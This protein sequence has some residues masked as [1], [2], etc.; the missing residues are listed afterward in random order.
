MRVKWKGTE[1]TTWREENEKEKGNRTIAAAADKWMQRNVNFTIELCNRSVC[2]KR[3]REEEEE[4]DETVS[5][6]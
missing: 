1:T 4:G 6:F 5:I 3:K 2:N